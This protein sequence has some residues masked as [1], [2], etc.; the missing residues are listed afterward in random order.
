VETGQLAPGAPVP[1]GLDRD[2]VVATA[3]ELIDERGV[4]GFTIRALGER[5]GV[6]APTI[7]WHVGTKAELLEA[8]VDR[9]VVDT[10]PPLRHEGPWDER[11]RH[12]LA[13]VRG[14]LLPHPRVTELLRTVH[15]RAYELWIREA[16]EIADAAGFR[17][18]GAP[19]YARAIVTTALACA[20]SEANI[21]AAPY[22]EV[23]PRDP[24]GRRYRV[25][26]EV[27]REGLP[28]DV[29]L[30]TTYDADEEF[31]RMAAI[32]VAGLVSQLSDQV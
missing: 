1:V 22:M 4:A 21:L 5:L 19:G 28:G 8:V 7:Y 26:P 23:D 25:R 15:S 10:A 17:P 16:L 6:R 20:Q 13:T 14:Q 27:L 2:T 9:V 12:L 18:E 11:V 30:T 29:A 32:F 31:E 3:V 24:T